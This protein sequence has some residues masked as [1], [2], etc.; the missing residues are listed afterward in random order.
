MCLD[1]I[2]ADNFDD[3]SPPSSPSPFKGEGIS[4]VKDECIWK[5]KAFRYG[6]IEG[7]RLKGEGLTTRDGVDIDY[8]SMNL[9]RFSA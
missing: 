8:T 4:K 6:R 5:A 2:N 3:A 1:S 9:L 7:K